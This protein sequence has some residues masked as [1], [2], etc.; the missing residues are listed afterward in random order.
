MNLYREF[1]TQKEID[2]EYNFALTVPDVDKWGAFYARESASARDK[3]DCSLDVRYGLTA[4]ETVDIFPSKKS[5]AP[6][7]VFIH[8]GYWYS[9]SAKDFSM[10]ANGLVDHG[11]TVAVMNYTLCPEVTIPE[12]TRQSRALIAWLR[13]EASSFNADPS[14]IFASGHSAGGQQ[15]AMLSATDWSG[16]YGLPHDVI[17]GGVA[18]SGIHDLRALPYSY[19][20]PALQLTHEVILRQSPCLDIPRFGPPLLVSCGSKETSEIQRLATEYHQARQANGLGGELLIQDGKHHF[21]AIEGLNDGGSSLCKSVLEFMARCEQAPDL[22][23]PHP[24]RPAA[25]RPV[26]WMRPGLEA[27]PRVPSGA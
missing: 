11:V 25:G 22:V 24:R 14:R 1:T 3:F 16:Q 20:Q 12:I 8:G 5:G 10:V 27:H 23:V 7:L 2:L 17:K 4:D 13:D 21:S 15:V 9:H 19:L 18:I 26:C 6:L